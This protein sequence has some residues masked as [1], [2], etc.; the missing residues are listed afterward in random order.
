MSDTL[1]TAAA[2]CCFVNI[3]VRLRMR[4]RRKEKW[5]NNIR[6]ST[7]FISRKF[8]ST[9][10]RTWSARFWRSLLLLLSSRPV[11]V[12]ASFCSYSF[13]QI[14]FL[15]PFC[16][17]SVQCDSRVAFSLSFFL[18]ISFA[19]TVFLCFLYIFQYSYVFL[20]MCIHE[21]CYVLF[22]LAYMYW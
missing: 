6:N 12:I 9:R 21:S 18:S 13:L 11:V 10:C 2:D 5:S 3:R 16:V 8:N 19:H 4:E 15:L 22:R 17:I 1:G 20:F 14:L 7:S